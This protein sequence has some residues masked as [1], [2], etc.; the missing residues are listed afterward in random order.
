MAKAAREK[1]RNTGQNKRKGIALRGIMGI[2][3]RRFLRKKPREMSTGSGGVL[4]ALLR[5]PQL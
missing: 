1:R 5:H 2:A 3:H 4:P